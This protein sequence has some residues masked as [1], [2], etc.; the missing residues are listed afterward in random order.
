VAGFPV[1]ALSVS[2]PL[3]GDE[4][5]VLQCLEHWWFVVRKGRGG[6]LDPETGLPYTTVSAREASDWLLERRGVAL[7][8][9]ACQRAFRSLASKGVVRRYQD[10]HRWGRH[11][12]SY[13][14]GENHPSEKQVEPCPT[15]VSKQLDA[16]VPSAG[17]LCPPEGTPVSNQTVL[18]ST[19]STDSSTQ[20]GGAVLTSS[21]EAEPASR[22]DEG[23]TASRA[24]SV[25]LSTAA[26][27]Q[28]AVRSGSGKATRGTPLAKVLA[29]CFELAGLAPVPACTPPSR[30]VSGDQVTELVKVSGCLHRVADP[31]LTAF[32]R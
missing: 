7:H 8:L 27:L 30:V 14:P 32:L 20:E 9:K 3:S 26:T 15:P 18:S 28:R 31:A 29:R 13:A 5:W 11:S 22:V 10:W 12:Y 21:L 6:H 17:R 2:V 1:S 4:G 16:P 25:S 23:R 24:P 19:S